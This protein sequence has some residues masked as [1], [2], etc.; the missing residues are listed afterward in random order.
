M[1]LNCVLKFL[2]EARGK[3]PH[4]NIPRDST[5]KGGGNIRRDDPLKFPYKSVWNS[6][7]LDGSLAGNPPGS[8]CADEVRGLTCSEEGSIVMASIVKHEQANLFPSLLTNGIDCSWRRKFIVFKS[9]MQPNAARKSIPSK[10]FSMAVIS[11]RPTN[12]HTENKVL[13]I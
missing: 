4:G 8:N 11:T 6:R 13:F 7:G 1:S 3:F 2:R 10:P 9:K 5:G 12:L